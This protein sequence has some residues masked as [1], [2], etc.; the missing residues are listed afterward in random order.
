MDTIQIIDYEPQYAE[1]FKRLNIAWIQKYFVVETH[2]LEQ[3]DHADEYIL[4]NGG[5]ILFA[6]AGSALVGTV[7]LIRVSEKEMELAKMAVD[8]SVQGQGIGKK[9]CLAA[10]DKAKQVGT[11]H[12]F[13]ESNRKLAPALKLYQSVGFQEVAMVETPY[14]RADIRMAMDFE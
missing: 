8:E 1:D 13:L 5:H 6:K 10:I 4:Q 9:L 11:K 12:L 2:D 3:L 7:A 14:A